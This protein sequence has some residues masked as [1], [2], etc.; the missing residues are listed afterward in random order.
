MFDIR[1]SNLNIGFSLI[2]DIPHIKVKYWIWFKHIYH[3]SIYIVIYKCTF[4]NII[5]NYNGIQKKVKRLIQTSFS[6]KKMVYSL[7]LYP[8]KKKKKKKRSIQTKLPFYL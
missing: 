1:H 6:L 5:I 7:E 8:M 2:F 3:I 4:Y